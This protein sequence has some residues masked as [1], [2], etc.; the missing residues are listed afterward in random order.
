MRISLPIVLGLAMLFPSLLRAQEQ[1]PMPTLPEDGAVLDNGCSN[2]T[3]MQTWEFSWSAVE[4]ADGY[5]LFVQR[6][7]SQH[8]VINRFVEDTTFTDSRRAYVAPHNT[9]AWTW[10]V[11]ARVKGKW[12]KWSSHRSFSVEPID[13]DCSMNN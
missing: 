3:D 7:G 9:D 8:P 13:T 1:A 12:S 11:R 10:R 4:G 2:Q 5:Q 6:L